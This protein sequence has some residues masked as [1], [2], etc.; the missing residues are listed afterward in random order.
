MWRYASGVQRSTAGSGVTGLGFHWLL[1]VRRAAEMCS[2][3]PFSASS[4]ETTVV[5]AAEI[6]KKN[7]EKTTRWL[8]RFARVGYAV[9]GKKNC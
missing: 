2:V 7:H 9:L 8:W 6:N 1:A 5:F 3:F 4:P